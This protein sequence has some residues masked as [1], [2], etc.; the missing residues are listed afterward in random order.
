MCKE[1]ANIVARWQL[2]HSKNLLALLLAK[3]DNP[4]VASG[5]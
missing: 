2:F 5:T 1:R 3:V 4:G